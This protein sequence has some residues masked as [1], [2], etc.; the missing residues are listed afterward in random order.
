MWNSVKTQTATLVL[1]ILGSVYVAALGVGGA[2]GLLFAAR[3]APEAAAIALVASGAALTL[4]WMVA[5]VVLANQDSTLDP[6]RLA[7]Y[8]PP[9][10][11]LAGALVVVG[12]AGPGGLIWGAYAVVSIAAWIIIAGPPAGVLTLIGSI[13]AITMTLVWIQGFSSW[14]QARSSHSRSSK[15]RTALLIFLGLLLVV[16]PMG[17]WL[18]LLSDSLTGFNW[19]LALNVAAWSPFGAFWSLPEALTQGGW[20][21]V[22]GRLGVGLVTIALGAWLLRV[23]L[24]V[25]MVGKA[26]KFP[27]K[28][29]LTNQTPPNSDHPTDRKTTR[30]LRGVETWTRLGASP[31]TA[32]VAERTRLYWY[33]DPRLAGQAGAVAI[34]LVIAIALPH[35]DMEGD[36]SFM[37]WQGVGMLL[38]A[39]ALVGITAGI[40]LQYDSTAY[41]IHVASGISGRADRLGRTLGSLALLAGIPALTSL[42]FGV[43]FRLGAEMA[44]A[45]FT[46]EILFAAGGYSAALLIG[47]QWVYPVQ[48]PG[49]SPLSSKGTGQFW[50]TMLLTFTQ[51]VACVI[52]IAIPLGLGLWC[53]FGAPEALI[54]ALIGCLL[55][56]IGLVILAIVVAGRILDASS[57]EILTKMSA[58]PGHKVQA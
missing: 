10:K 50:T 53:Y 54:F 57:V 41:W 4:G 28:I 42:I 9:S 13:G 22:A 33:R 20:G 25:A 37:I 7:A 45:L 6:R 43:V 12:A 58:W 14:I 44:F 31:A 21:L 8:L 15:E 30:Y 40:T 46:V 2:V 11:K 36:F 23:Q 49:A 29:V 35:F 5:P 24:P 32:A 1:S 39:S 34:L 47:S 51:M 18:P 19:S 52:L 26:N 56:A 27:S 3:S 17:L 48:P 38:L 16:A 55:W